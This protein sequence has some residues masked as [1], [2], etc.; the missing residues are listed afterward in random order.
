MLSDKYKKQKS[1]V[2][3]CSEVINF[4]YSDGDEVENRILRQVREAA[5]VS[6]ASDELQRLM[7]DWPSEYHFSPLRANL[8]SSFQLHKSKRILEIG[9]GCGAITRGL[10]EQCPD[11]QIIA[12]DGSMRRAQITRARCRDLQN[13]TVCCDSFT[14]FEHPE[15]FDLI[16]MIGVLEYSPS[17]FEGDDPVTAAIEHARRLLS[18]GG[19]LVVAMEN[20][21]GLKYFNG[22]GEDHNSQP[23]FG[24]ND[25]YQPGTFCTFGKKQLQDKLLGAGF[26]GTEFVYPFPDYKLPRLL[27]REESF[28]SNHL[29]IASLLGQYPARDYSRDTVPLF[30][31]SQVWS[32]A[33]N[34]GVAQD[35]ANSFLVFAFAG[36]G[37]LSDISDSWLTKAYS[38]IRKK[39]HLIETA[40]RVKGDVVMVEKALLYP[41]V[42]WGDGVDNS[43]IK[44]QLVNDTYVQGTPYGM[45]LML[46]AH[47]EGMLEYLGHYLTPWVE[48]LRKKELAA[49]H[50]GNQSSIRVP[51]CFY[52][53]VP[54]NFIVDGDGQLCVIDQEWE[55]KEPLE[56]GFL[57]FRGLYSEMSRNISLFETSDLFSTG[58]VEDILGKLFHL[59]DIPFDDECLERYVELEVTFQVQMVVYS[60]EE[61]DL[62]DHLL[63]FFR[64]ERVR[65][66]D[67]G[68]FLMAGGVRCYDRA[69]SD[70]SHLTQELAERD[71]L[72]QSVFQSRSW[73]L[74]S[75]LREVGTALKIGRGKIASLVK[76]PSD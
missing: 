23:F 27:V 32:L 47:R 69:L 36:E 33:A 75:A 68:D 55:S 30:Q 28:H 66:S 58:T 2:W 18:T 34:N 50:D 12:L 35:L 60:V 3:A 48:W 57:L 46:Q 10:G 37:S 51:G 7:V 19:I 15:L 56:L 26:L 1:D 71:A 6:I 5:D 13:V 22:C 64:E 9:S 44:Q 39:Q 20:Q 62:Y 41:R 73:K 43:I 72:L 8:L 25:Q 65:C 49:P 4:D 16:T 54:S 52:D 40:F 24:I 45:G 70:V 74:T 17:F 29:D 14:D 67:I 53:C 61:K 31:E 42:E 21:L 59:F 63:G 38:C 11:S 76:T